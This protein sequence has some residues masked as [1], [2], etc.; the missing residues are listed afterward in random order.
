M[1]DPVTGRPLIPAPPGQL[2]IPGIHYPGSYIPPLPP[3]PLPPPPITGRQQNSPCEIPH[4]IVGAESQCVARSPLGRCVNCERTFCSTH[5]SYNR[6]GQFGS[7]RSSFHL[8]RW[9]LCL[10]CQNLQVDQWEEE[11]RRLEERAEEERQAHD[12]RV[13]EREH[14]VGW[15][16]AQARIAELEREAEDYAWFSTYRADG[17]AIWAGSCAAVAFAGAIC[18]QRW[19]P[20]LVGLAGLF[21]VPALRRPV[22]GRADELLR[23]VSH[24]R[25][26]RGCGDPACDRCSTV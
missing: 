23:E 9:N 25:T 1:T 22:S 3:P 17:A 20:L 26:L 19:W 8:A 4:L 2:P 21:A 12:E 5:G 13:A 18:V 14:R 24:L 7:Y 16:A 6:D 15:P 10:P 11:A